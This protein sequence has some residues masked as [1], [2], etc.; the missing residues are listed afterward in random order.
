[1]FSLIIYLSVQ[2][3]YDLEFLLLVFIVLAFNLRHLG[4]TLLLC[5]ADFYPL[6]HSQMLAQPC[7]LILREPQTPQQRAVTDRI[8]HDMVVGPSEEYIN[9]D[10]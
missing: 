2:T 5:L 10:L 4:S 7:E 1:M 9:E 8:E 6:I 3:R